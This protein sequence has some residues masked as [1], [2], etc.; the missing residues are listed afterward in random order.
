MVCLRQCRTAEHSSVFLNLKMAHH[1]NQNKNRPAPR[2][3]APPPLPLPLVTAVPSGV[4]MRACMAV[5]RAGGEVGAVGEPPSLQ[6]RRHSH[7]TWGHST[8]RTPHRAPACVRLLDQFIRFILRFLEC[9]SRSLLR[10]FFTY[11]RQ[12]QITIRSHFTRLAFYV[13]NFG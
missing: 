9:P 2:A 3:A 7:R 8:R 5:M 13:A 11:V 10:A 12:L 6:C 4:N 1:Q